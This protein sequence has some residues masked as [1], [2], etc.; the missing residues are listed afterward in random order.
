MCG[1][2]ETV[3][4]WSHYVFFCTCPA[5]AAARE[6]WAETTRKAG[7]AIDP[8][9]INQQLRT[10]TL[11]LAGDSAMDHVRGD[12]DLKVAGG[13]AA[14]VERRLRGC[15]GGAIDGYGESGADTRAAARRVVMAGARVLTLA[16]T[17]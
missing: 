14:E 7:A 11:M 12:H 8:Q 6:S 1:S 4:T 13:A 2:A 17:G 10:L 3:G 15:V 9:G 16:R 5:L